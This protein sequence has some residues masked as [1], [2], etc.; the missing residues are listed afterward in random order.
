MARDLASDSCAA[1]WGAAI[2][3][4]TVVS[5]GGARRLAEP[6]AIRRSGESAASPNGCDKRGLP[7][8]HVPPTRG[9]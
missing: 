2:L 7:W 4:A 8:W 1:A 5:R 6:P 9:V 3:A